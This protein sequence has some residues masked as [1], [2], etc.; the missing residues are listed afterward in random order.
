MSNDLTIFCEKPDHPPAAHVRVVENS[1]IPKQARV[2]AIVDEVPLWVKY[3][4]LSF[5]QHLI[6][7]RGAAYTFRETGKVIDVLRIQ[8][9]SFDDVPTD[10]DLYLVAMDRERP[11]TLVFTADQLELA[12]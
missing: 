8:E 3:N 11:R 10:E 7:D 5:D 1:L 12:V 4:R 9:S 2:K 6:L